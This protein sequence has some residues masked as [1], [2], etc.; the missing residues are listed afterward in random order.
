MCY[1]NRGN[2]LAA[3]GKLD[4][5]IDDFG[6]A[7]EIREQLIEK[8]SRRELRWDLFSSLFNRAIAFSKMKDWKQAG[9]DIEKGG[10]LLRELI[11][12]GRRHVIGSFLKTAGFRCLFA[13]ELGD[14]R[15]AAQWAGDG[16]RWFIEEAQADRMN[17]LLVRDAALFAGGLKANIKVLAAGGL[18]EELVKRFLSLLKDI[19][20]D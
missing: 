1:N 10:G 17:E 18:D 12:E 3:Q 7:I 6:R 14:E 15:Q 9:G 4:E 20:S 19:T 8:E 5:A 13:K 2:A 11:E 16:M